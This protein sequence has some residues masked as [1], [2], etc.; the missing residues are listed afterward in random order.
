[1][2]SA[3]QWN[4][5]LHAEGFAPIAPHTSAE[6][7]FFI[8]R[9]LMEK[10]EDYT[11]SKL[12]V[13][14]A[15]EIHEHETCLYRA[16]KDN[17]PWYAKRF[18]TDAGERL[19]PAIPYDDQ[20]IYAAKKDGKIMIALA[21]C[22]NND[23]KYEQEEMGFEINKKPGDCN[24]LHFYGNLDK[25]VFFGMDAVYEKF[26]NYAMGDLKSMGI[27]RVYSSCSGRLLILYRLAG[28][29]EVD[30]KIIDETG[31]YEYMIARDL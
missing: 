27:K 1:M 20:V 11:F 8:Y 13:N 22:V 31:E 14:N 23:I 16:F 7:I 24:G 21:V 25:N 5:V 29:R 17:Y 18:F 15:S 12:D 3:M 2:S 28:F 30:K 9:E 19:V 6:L 26:M 10:P 4:F